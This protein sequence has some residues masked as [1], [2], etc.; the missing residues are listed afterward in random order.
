MKI[1]KHDDQGRRKKTILY[2][3][4]D[5][6]YYIVSSFNNDYGNQSMV[7]ESDAEGNILDYAELLVSK[8]C[9]HDIIVDYLVNN[10]IILK[11]NEIIYFEGG[12]C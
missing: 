5:N 8:P 4:V 9:H 7:F 3:S 6:I 2:D 12:E 1:I 10:I 11:K